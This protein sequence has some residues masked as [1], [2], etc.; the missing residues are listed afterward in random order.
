MHYDRLL[1]MVVLKRVLWM[2]EVEVLVVAVRHPLEEVEDRHFLE[3]LAVCV[4]CYQY[5]VGLVVE[6]LVVHASVAGRPSLGD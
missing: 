1:L 4:W 2:E 5:Q 3:D 6:D